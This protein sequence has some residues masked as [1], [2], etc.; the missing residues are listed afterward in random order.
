MRPDVE[1]INSMNEDCSR[2][3]E[4]LLTLLHEL[5]SLVDEFERRNNVEWLSKYKEDLVA[6]VSG[7][8][9]YSNQYHSWWLFQVCVKSLQSTR[10]TRP[11]TRISSSNAVQ[12]LLMYFVCTL[13]QCKLAVLQILSSIQPRKERKRPAVST[14]KSK[15]KSK[16]QF[17]AFG[18]SLNDEIDSDEAS[19]DEKSGQ[20]EDEAVEDAGGD[21][22]R[23][24]RVRK[25]KKSK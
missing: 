14:S 25:N 8:L 17:D 11:S 2:S 22:F 16:P 9:T 4:E 13:N 18:G 12:N 5:S 10:T 6:C 7:C 15:R 20:V 23:K 3:A 19:G 21:A 1:I 24:P